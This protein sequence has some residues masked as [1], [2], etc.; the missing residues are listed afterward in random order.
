M[1]S[2]SPVDTSQHYSFEYLN[3]PSR[4]SP[5]DFDFNETLFPAGVP[6]Q[7]D[8]EEGSEPTFEFAIEDSGESTVGL[9]M[10]GWISKRNDEAN[11]DNDNPLPE[12]TGTLLSTKVSTHATIRQS[13]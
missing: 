11:A 7:I 10:E 13:N 6:P 8:E 5:S 1:I 4:H 2:M 3:S 9:P 12:S